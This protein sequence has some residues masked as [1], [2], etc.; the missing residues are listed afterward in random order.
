MWDFFQDIQCIHMKNRTDRFE[1][2]EKVKKQIHIP[3]QYFHVL[4]HPES[5]KRGCYESHLSVMKQALRKKKKLC[6]IFEDD[7]E[8]SHFFSQKKIFEI[9]YFIKNYLDW[10]VF[11]LGCFPD[12]WN[13]RQDWFRGNIHKVKAAQTHAYVVNEKFMKKIVHRKYDNTPIDEVFMSEARCFAIF[14]SLFRQA[15]TISDVSSIEITSIF[16]K[17]RFITDL[18]EWYSIFFGVPL[19]QILFNVLICVTY[20]IFNFRYKKNGNYTIR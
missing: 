19:R 10:D 9:I 16:P 13:S 8:V 3:I 7:L 1:L 14:P 2:I 15:S 6:L 20:Y 4:P 12:V 17:K 5:G 18:V 11:Y